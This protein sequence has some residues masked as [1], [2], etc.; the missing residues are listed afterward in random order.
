MSRALVLRHH[1]E[2]RPGLVGDALEARG[3]TL[4][5]TMMD[6]SSATPSV[7]GYDLLVILGSKHAVYDPAVEE[8]WFGRE[9]DVV[10][11]ADA[12]SIPILGICFGAQALCRYFGGEVARS[13]HPEV[14]WFTID[15]V[16][17]S[18]IGPGPWFEY[19]FDVCT[20]PPTAQL[21]ATSA[22]AVQAFAVGRH[23]GVQF[24]PEIDEHQLA[25]WMAAGGAEDAR[26]LGLDPA[27]LVAQT[28]R[29]TPAARGRVVD[30]IDVVLRHVGAAS[31]A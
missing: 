21:W 10:A 13:E 18:G 30:L 31:V 25:D 27:E 12:R 20:L 24:H 5:V 14:G 23:V 6:E 4:D 2:D 11:D 17:G 29:E 19:H 9:L 22:R 15:A 28:A 7:D 16:N 3:F 8:A 26:F 1:L